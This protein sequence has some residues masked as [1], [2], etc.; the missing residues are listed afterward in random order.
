MLKYLLSF[1]ISVALTRLLI[2]FR[3][4][5]VQPISKFLPTHSH[6]SGTPTLGGIAMVAAPFCTFAIYNRGIPEPR[7]VYY[8]GA[9]CFMVGLVDDLVKIY[10]QDNKG[11]SK[12]I[13]L[14][15]L[16]ASIGS[17]LLLSWEYN[18]N[19]L[20]FAVHLIT[21]LTSAAAFDVMDGLDGLLSLT[22]LLILSLI[23]A[24]HADICRGILVVASGILG[25]LVFNL[26]PA[27]IFMGD[28]GSM[29]IGGMVGA[30]IIKYNFDLSIIAS[31][32]APIVEL[33]SVA[34]KLSLVYLGLKS[35]KFVAPIHHQF[36][37]WIGEESTVLCFTLVTL[38]FCLL[39]YTI[40]LLS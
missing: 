37:R 34:L 15:L 6:K 29:F 16:T 25:F 1:S 21:I 10:T 4:R 27:R 2:V 28:S 19:Y 40:P 39:A 12:L 7:L 31:C 30:C 9:I 11:L 26:K 33:L 22:S 17:Y 14:L 5:I 32:I 18:G 38:V 13:K 24:L 23:A 8:V 35:P 20:L 3:R 36:E